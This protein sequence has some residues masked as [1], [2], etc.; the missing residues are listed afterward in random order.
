MIKNRF[1]ELFE[2]CSDELKELAFTHSSYANQYGT[3]SNERL[4]FLGDSILSTI[5]SDYLYKHYNK[6]EGK[7]SKIRA[8]F[9]CTENLSELA[10]TLDV[11]PKIKFGKS[12]QGNISD[13]ILADIVECMIG[14]MYLTYGLHS[15]STAVLEALKVKEQ[16]RA[17]MK[18][19]D[20]KSELQ[21]YAQAN[22]L[23]LEYKVEK[24]MTKGGQ[25]NFRATS[26]INGEFV[27]FG[28][29]STKREAEQNSAKLALTKLKKGE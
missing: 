4:E 24:Y 1:L 17:G 14:A 13:A 26:F 29:G 23:K 7:M 12:F 10:K 27:S 8:K 6:P 5:V 3:L 19:N 16:L 15:I 25:E 28:Q 18:P 11:A 22:K 9:V 21:E 20:Y 2:K